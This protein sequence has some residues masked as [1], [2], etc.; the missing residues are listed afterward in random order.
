MTN[1]NRFYGCVLF[2][3]Q[4]DVSVLVAQCATIEQVWHYFRYDIRKPIR[5][6]LSS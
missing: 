2:A 5:L 3:R 1:A 4:R 6:R